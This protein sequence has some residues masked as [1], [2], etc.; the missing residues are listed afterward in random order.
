M[1]AM[2]RSIIGYVAIVAVIIGAFV[3]FKRTKPG[4]KGY[5]EQTDKSVR[6]DFLGKSFTLT[7]VASMSELAQGDFVAYHV[8]E[9]KRGDIKLDHRVARVLAREGEIV[10]G[11]YG[12]GGV[13]V[14]NKPVAA[15]LKI[16]HKD[17]YV[18]PIKVPR[19]CV[20]VLADNPQFGMD[21]MQLGPVP[22][23]SVMGKFVP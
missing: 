3:L 5:I 11:R 4:A 16:D 20:F 10:E 22:L 15:D 18:A 19:G 1:N 6:S 14:D 12:D 9:E 2:V 8:P 7:P 13:K 23:T 21:S 17:W